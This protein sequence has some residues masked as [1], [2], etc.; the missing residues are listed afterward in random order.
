MLTAAMLPG[1][2]VSPRGHAGGS[3][4]DPQL[5]FGGPDSGHGPHTAGG[6]R[7]HSAG[8][9]LRLCAVPHDPDGHWVTP[10]D[11]R[12][13]AAHWPGGGGPAAV[14]GP[15]PH[16]QEPV[17]TLLLGAR[18]LSPPGQPGVQGEDV[19]WGPVAV[20]RGDD[21]QRAAPV[22]K[23]EACGAALPTSEH[24]TQV[25]PGLGPRGLV[26]FRRG[27]RVPE[28]SQPPPLP[29]ASAAPRGHESVS[30]P[31]GTEETLLDLH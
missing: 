26:S 28:R 29:G 2:F 21:G 10:A 30:V 12:A 13:V 22:P 27:S 14:P 18:S 25:E 19:V 5:P 1:P 17:L 7:P 9:S 11:L 6:A 31:G 8:M 15:S 4:D 23:G 20:T 24:G 3:S 16:C